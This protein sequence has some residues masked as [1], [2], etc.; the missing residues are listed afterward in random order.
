[1]ALV[2]YGIFIEDRYSIVAGGSDSSGY[3]NSG[4]LLAA[5]ELRT[6][7][8]TPTEFGPSASLDRIKFLPL[9]FWFSPNS[10]QIT[11]TYPTGL[12]LHFALTGKLFGWLTGPRI[13]GVFA[14]L[15]A[16][17]LC[18]GLGREL[19]LDAT[20]AATAATIL[21]LCPLFFFTSF[22]P[23]SDTLACTWCLASARL[24]LRARRSRGWAVACGAAFAVAVLVRPTNFLLAPALLVLLGLD[25]RRL[26]LA[27]LGGLPGVVWLA[28]YNHTLYGGALRSGYG[29]W[30]ET[31]AW[32]WGPPTAW[33]FA[34][35]LALLLP[36]PL[37]GLA[38][39]PLARRETRTRGF[40]ALAVWFAA[41]VGLY[42]FYE[43]SHEVWWCLRFIL[44][45]VPALILAGML[46]F[47]TLVKRVS[48]PQQRRIHHLGA[49]AL[50]GWI[51]AL[52]LY[53]NREFAI[54]GTKYGERTYAK[55][56]AAALEK[57]PPRTLVATMTFSGAFYYYTDFP[58]L[59]WDQVTPE[60]FAHFASLAQKAGRTVAAVDFKWDE[61]RA[62]KEHCRGDW[63]RVAEVGDAVLWRLKPLAG[64]GAAP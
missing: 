56:C 16:V 35:W 33:H 54:T 18:F 60:E 45:A 40:L 47:D 61:P 2:A 64:G 9:G 4:R 23:L 53:W 52:S 17:L 3:L 6:D 22:Q 44:P 10:P 36:S 20:L 31:F 19:G 8:R 42:T 38:I 57:F 26:G 1:V 14:A 11:P 32:A 46:G 55:A 12:P 63:E 7:L 34:K 13:V 37:L 29:P 43:I 25:W 39:I 27:I 28:L 5:G 58:I 62:L 21:A 50:I 30:S 59:R 24:A 15:G 41:I 48:V 51:A 49:L